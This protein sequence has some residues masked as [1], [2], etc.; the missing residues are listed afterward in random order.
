MI[1]LP[2]SVRVYLATSPCDKGSVTPK[3]AQSS[4]PPRHRAKWR[5]HPY[6]HPSAR[7]FTLPHAG[8][9]GPIQFFLLAEDIGPIAVDP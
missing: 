4:A 3:K 9:T 5:G 7:I 1:H 2:A 6:V 8:E